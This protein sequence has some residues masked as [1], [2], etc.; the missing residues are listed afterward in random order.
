VQGLSLNDAVDKMRGA[1][2]SKITLTIKRDGVDKPLEL[3]LLREVIKIQVVKSHG[4]GQH[5][6]HPAVAVHRTGRRGAA[7]GGAAAQARAG[8]Q[9]TGLILDLRNNP[10]GL[11]DQAVAVSERL[12]RPGR[13]RLHPRPPSRGQ[14]ALGRQAAT[15]SN[16][17][18][19]WC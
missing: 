13:D 1:P 4:A 11:L 14:P 6:L 5:R 9:L 12:H 7:Q 3:S 17:R 8:G 16:G 10:G 19:W 2:N 15:S 18:R